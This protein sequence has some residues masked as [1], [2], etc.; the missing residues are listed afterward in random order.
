MIL[1]QYILWWIFVGRYFL[2]R[3]RGHNTHFTIDFRDF[4][5]CFVWIR[6]PWFE[7]YTYTNQVI[8]WNQI[9][10]FVPFEISQGTNYEIWFQLITWFE[11]HMLVYGE[12][13][14]LVVNIMTDSAMTAPPGKSGI[15]LKREIWTWA[16]MRTRIAQVAERRARNLEVRVLNP[17]SGSSFSLEIL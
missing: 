5:I 15:R 10:W 14:S 13:S 12:V 3:K 6:K 1:P 7:Y 8:N 11:Y 2:R 16:G 9:T 17:G 4:N